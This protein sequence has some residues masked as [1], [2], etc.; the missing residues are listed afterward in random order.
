MH[1]QY[2]FP[3]HLTVCLFIKL[4]ASDKY[5]PGSRPGSC[6]LNLRLPLLAPGRC[7]F[8]CRPTSAAHAECKSPS[9]FL[10]IIHH[11]PALPFIQKPDMLQSYIQ[12]IVNPSLR[13][14]RSAAAN[15][16]AIVGCTM[17]STQLYHSTKSR[18]FALLASQW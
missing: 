10:P 11:L 13:S 8:M 15:Q 3:S 16:L 17:R 6:H 9:K 4:T 7:A 12:D 2:F 5:I 14:L 18:L 1:F